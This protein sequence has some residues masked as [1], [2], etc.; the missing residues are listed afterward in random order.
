MIPAREEQDLGRPDVST[1]E[2]GVAES[3]ADRLQI[4]DQNDAMPAGHVEQPLLR[5]LHRT[6]EIA[7][8][9][10]SRHALGTE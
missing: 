10:E 8:R 7:A 4:P 1:N 3:E 5:Q 9:E 6:S 2:V